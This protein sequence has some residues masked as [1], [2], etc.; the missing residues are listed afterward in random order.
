MALA[1][2]L[3]DRRDVAVAH[4]GL[5]SGERRA[6]G[7][8]LHGG[9]AADEVALF[10]A[11]DRLDLVD[12]VR[13]FDKARVGKT[14]LLQIIDQRERHLR[15]ADKADSAAGVRRERFRGELRIIARGVV[16]GSKTRRGEP[17]L[18]AAP[19]PVAVRSRIAD[20]A[21]RTLA[22]QGHQVVAR[23]HHRQRITIGRRQIRE[24][25]DVT[26]HMIVIVLHQ[27]HVDLLALHCGA[28]RRPAPLQLSGRDRRLQSFRKLLHCNAPRPIPLIPAQA[29]N[30][31]GSPLCWDER[32]VNL[33]RHDVD[34]AVE[35]TLKKALHIGFDRR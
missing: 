4:A 17:L 29:G 8:V 7:A 31:P 23:K 33:M 1:V 19:H 9:S 13:G 25:F 34:H 14:A 35:I 15:Y 18:D 24:I 32:T 3:R 28:H 22:H 2:A 30:Q 27:Q 5:D 11:F 12:Q 21:K 26:A 6:H 10:G 16:T 20:T